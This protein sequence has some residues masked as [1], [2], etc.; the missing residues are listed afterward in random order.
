[1]TRTAELFD[2]QAPDFDRRTG[3]EP[4][5]CR[6]IAATVLALGEIG[7]NDLIV[8]IGAGTGQI[9]VELAA[10][11]RYVG[12]DLSSGMLD[13]F[14]VRSRESATRCGLVRADA[15]RTWP[16]VSGSSR[17]VFSSRAFHLLAHEHVADEA[18]RVGRPDGATLIIGRVERSP[19]HVKARM[20][21]EMRGRLRRLGFAPRGEGYDRR[22]IEACVQRGGVALEPVTA[23]TWTVAVSAQQSLDA[24]RSLSGLGG[25][26]VPL[27]TRETV[28]RELGEWAGGVFGDLDRKFESEEAYVLRAVRLFCVR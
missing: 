2:G 4:A 28:L 26:D 5:Q 20:A 6:Q 22:L 25:I 9:G 19:R 23:V 10:A 14:R 27:G 17:A 13:R 1:V 8:E 12:C 16:L 3:L 7:A 18:F 11:R 24:W 15:R 21:T